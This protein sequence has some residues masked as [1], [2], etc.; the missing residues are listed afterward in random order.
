MKASEF[1]TLPASLVPF[2]AYFRPEVPPWEWLRQIDVALS[3]LTT[4]M[5]P[6]PAPAGVHLEGPVWLGLA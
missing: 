5:G 1:F 6:R 2:A 4:P 3:A